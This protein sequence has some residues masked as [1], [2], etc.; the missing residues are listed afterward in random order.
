MQKLYS[1]ACLCEPVLNKPLWLNKLVRLNKAVL[2]ND[3]LA[4]G[5]IIDYGHLINSA[6]EILDY[7][8]V[9]EKFD[10]SPKNSSF[11]EF[12]KLCVALPSCW[13]ENKNYQLPDNHDRLSAFRSALNNVRFFIKWVYIRLRQFR[14]KYSICG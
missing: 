9:I 2:Y 7:D 11:I 13:E 5:G 3:K 10:I 12:T 8:R 6:G 1:S 14:F 4:Y